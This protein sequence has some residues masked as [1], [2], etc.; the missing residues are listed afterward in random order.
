MNELRFIIIVLFN[1]FFSLTD[2]FA[3]CFQSYE[4][5]C[6]YCGEAMTENNING[7]CFRNSS[8]NSY[9]FIF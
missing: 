6:F 2:K 1:N 7:T 5:I 9:Y 4:M 8:L 3:K